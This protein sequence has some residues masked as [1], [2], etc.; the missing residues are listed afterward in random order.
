MEQYRK[1]YKRPLSEGAE[2]DLW[3]VGHETSPHSMHMTYMRHPL[4]DAETLEEIM[5]YPY[6]DFEHGEKEH[7]KEQVNIPIRILPVQTA[8]TR[9]SR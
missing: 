7:Q 2:I 9:Q 5:E 4:E 8:H 3:G 6:P 1:Y